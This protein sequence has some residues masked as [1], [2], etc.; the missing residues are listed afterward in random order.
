MVDIGLTVS[1]GFSLAL[2]VNQVL[3]VALNGARVQEASL[4]PFLQ[5]QVQ[6]GGCGVGRRTSQKMNLV[7]PYSQTSQPPEM[8]GEKWLHVVYKSPG[9]WYFVITAQWTETI[10][11]ISTCMFQL[12]EQRKICEIEA[13]GINYRVFLQMRK[14]RPERLS[15]L[16]NILSFLSFKQNAFWLHYL[17][18][19]IK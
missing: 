13:T 15:D 8:I 2:W 9:L 7:P 11:L 19:L 12:T 3:T 14:W 16:A 4:L 18:S 5:G 17:F 6:W 1:Q 10:W